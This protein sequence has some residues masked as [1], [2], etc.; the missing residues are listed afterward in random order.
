MCSNAK[1]ITNTRKIGLNEINLQLYYIK[2]YDLAKN[3]CTAKNIVNLK[4]SITIAVY[5]RSNHN[6]LDTSLKTN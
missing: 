5:K 1:S 3:A 4:N 6:L 2:V